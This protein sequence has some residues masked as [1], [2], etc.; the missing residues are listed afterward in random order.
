MF[1]RI[2]T[3]VFLFTALLCVCGCIA[4]SGPQSPQIRADTAQI[5]TDTAP[6][7]ATVKAE[8]DAAIQVYVACLDRAAKRLDDRLSDPATIAHGMMAACSR[9]FDAEVEVYSRY[10]EEGLQGREKVA[11]RARQAS[12]D[13]AIELVLKNRKSA[14][15]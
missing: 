9:E 14:A 12:L 1:V 15:R 8:R 13:S 4:A 11:Q 3:R 6:D 5:R 2:G 10:L 7:P